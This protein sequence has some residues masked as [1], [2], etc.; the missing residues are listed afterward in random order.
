MV[1]QNWKCDECGFSAVG[2][3]PPEKCPK[4]GG[5]RKCFIREHEF[6]FPEEELGDVVEA[7]WKISYGLYLVSSVDAEKVN[8][9]IVNTFFQI[10][11]D[12]PRFAVG[13]NRKNLTHEYIGKSGYFAVSILGRNDQRIVRR[14][15]YRS[16]RDFDKFKNVPVIKERTGC[17]ILKDAIGY[18]ECAVSKGMKLNAGTHDIF[19]GDVVGGRVFSD[20]EPLAYAY[21]H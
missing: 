11:S 15:G 14:F 8:G 5:G 7:C 12:P 9:Q 2:V 1:A 4:C 13:I 3:F 16:G 21:Y 19:V 20:K 10:T 6:K 18:I 17:P